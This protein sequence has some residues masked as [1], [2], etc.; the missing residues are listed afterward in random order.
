M[1]I[2][3]R[4]TTICARCGLRHMG[5]FRFFRFAVGYCDNCFRLPGPW[6][7]GPGHY[8]LPQYSDY[9]RVQ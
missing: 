8:G 1:A 9:V 7:I 5:G 2:R 4:K 6:L 3:E